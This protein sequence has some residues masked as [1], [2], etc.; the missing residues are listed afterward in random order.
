MTRWLALCG[1]LVA[2]G[3][4]PAR[5]AGRP[6]WGGT[7]RVAAPPLRTQDPR[8]ALD[9]GSLLV[10]AL[11]HQPLLDLPGAE[12]QLVLLRLIEPDGTGPDLACTLREGAR[13]HDGRVVTSDDVAWSLARLAAGPAGSPARVIPEIL[14]VDPIDARRFVLRLRAPVPRTT[15][16]RLLAL[17]QAAILP[18]GGDGRV[19]AGPFALL[20]RD[21]GGALVLG[22][23]QAHPRGRPFV[24]RVE[25]WPARA[26]SDAADRLYYGDADVALRWSPRLEGLPDVARVD[27]PTVEAVVLLPPPG[28]RAVV[29]AG[30]AELGVGG[31]LVSRFDRESEVAT[32]LL[33]GLPPRRHE[34]VGGPVVVGVAASPD[35]LE[36]VAAMLRDLAVGAGGAGSRVAP[37][38]DRS[39]TVILAPWRWTDPTPAM[40]AL[41]ALGAAGAEPRALRDLVA[42]VTADDDGPA[43]AALADVERR[44]D[45]SALLHVRRAAWL[46]GPLRDVRFDGHGLLA[47]A[48]AWWGERR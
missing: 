4:S 6:S 21:A 40:A 8:D 9:D 31:S 15:V 44:G 5:A 37:S 46:R 7:V 11:V 23:H 48:D 47:L 16:E 29:P 20:D 43:R 42:R 35:D 26:A 22:P 13:F 25:I 38:D 39:S 41:Q 33:P 34:R 12:P 28:P 3:S 32:A 17:P 27:G 14:T 36:D 2:L 10:A 24:D 19:G 1:C 18:R 45:L 30:V